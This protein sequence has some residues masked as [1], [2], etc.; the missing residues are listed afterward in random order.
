MLNINPETVCDLI[1][2]A[3]EFHAKEEVVIPETPDSPADD[4]GTQVL[5]DHADDLT[6]QEMRRAIFELEPD[7]KTELL[8]LMQLGRGDYGAEDWEAALGEAEANWSEGIV[9]QM[10]ATPL[11]AGYLQEGL[12]RL[13]YGCE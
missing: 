11:L 8:A 13:G 4:W 9:D 2:R 7:Q 5:A 6:F 10:I 12:N 3:R 1:S